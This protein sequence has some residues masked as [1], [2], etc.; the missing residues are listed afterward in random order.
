MRKK[1]PSEYLERGFAKHWLAKTKSGNEC[2]PESWRAV[3]YCYVGAIRRASNKG[4]LTETQK[5]AMLDWTRDKVQK[6]L[7]LHSISTWNDMSARIQE[8]VVQMAR[9]AEIHLGLRKSEV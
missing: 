3:A 5:L 9:A 4:A 7:K 8:D 6:D 2:S 1:L